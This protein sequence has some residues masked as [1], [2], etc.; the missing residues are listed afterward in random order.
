[1]TSLRTNLVK[2]IERLPKPTNVASAMQLLLVSCGSLMGVAPVSIG[3][4]EVRLGFRLETV[5]RQASGFHPRSLD[6]GEP[7]T[8]LGKGGDS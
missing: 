6:A 8:Y 7:S 4:G 1:M 5:G 2:R 3:L